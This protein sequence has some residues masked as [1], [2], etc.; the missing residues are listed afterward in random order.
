MGNSSPYKNQAKHEKYQNGKTQIVAPTN[1][2]ME[3]MRKDGSIKKDRIGDK[4][5]EDIPE[6]VEANDGSYEKSLLKRLASLQGIVN[7]DGET[8]ENSHSDSDITVGG[9]SD[10]KVSP[11]SKNEG[12]TSPAETYAE[13]EEDEPSNKSS[14]ARKKGRRMP[15]YCQGTRH[16]TRKD[17]N[18]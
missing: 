12:S 5:K 10:G 15:W 9:P 16:K 1:H 14:Y 8:S 17:A 4:R 7:D 18:G 6:R 2:D 13:D 11:V 3:Q